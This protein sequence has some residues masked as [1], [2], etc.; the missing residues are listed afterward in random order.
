MDL[1]KIIFDLCILEPSEISLPNL[2]LPTKK[3]EKFNILYRK[4]QQKS[5]LKDHHQSIYIAY[6]LG[7]FLEEEIVLR[8][9]KSL[10]RSQMTKH[11]YDSSIRS[12]YIFEKYSTHQIFR[13]KNL[14][15]TKIR[16]L[17]EKDFKFLLT[18]FSLEP[19]NLEEE[20]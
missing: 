8:T 16:R 6:L 11:F 9:Q 10:Y 14:T 3:D 12:Y 7:K 13:T 18:D 17:K 15:L 2:I 19:Q 20:Y 4:L 1:P 5:R